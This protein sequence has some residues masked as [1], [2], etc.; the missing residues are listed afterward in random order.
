[1]KLQN[2]HSI[3]NKIY[4]FNRIN[5]EEMIVTE[6][7][8]FYPYFYEPD[9]KGTIPTYDGKLA[10]KVVLN[11]PKDVAKNRSSISYESDIL[12][13]KRYL[14]DRVPVIDFSPTKY[15]L[16]DIEILTEE[17]PDVDKA[18]QPISCITIYISTTKEYYTWYLG[19]WGGIMGEAIML[20]D[21]VQS[22]RNEQPDILCAWN[23]QFDYTYLFNRLAKNTPSTEGIVFSDAI[24]PI[25]CS[26]SGRD[27]IFFPAGISIVDYMGLY[28]KLTL[29]KKRSY[30]LDYIS[31]ED[32]GEV[33]WKETKFNVLDETVKAKNH[34]DVR[35]LVSL[36]D[37]YK[38]LVHFDGIRRFTKCLWEDL[39]TER[40]EIEGKLQ[41]IS[42]NSKPLDMVFLQ[43]AHD[44]G[45]VLPRKQQDNADEE[46]IE[47]A[48]R[49]SYAQGVFYDVSEYDLSG[50]YLY[51]AIDMCL[52]SS[53]IIDTSKLFV[54]DGKPWW[55]N[56]VLPINVTDRKTQDVKETYYV[57]QNPNALIP[58]VLSKLVNDKN[59]L[60]D[61]TLKN[62]NDENLE[63]EYKSKKGL[64]LSAWGVLVNKYFRLYDVRVGSM[65]T[66]IVRD[67]MHYVREKIEFKGYTVVKLDT[68]S[69]FV[70]DGGKDISELLNGIIKEWSQLR[71]GKASQITFELKGHF[72]KLLL[73]TNCRH[74]GY[75][76]G[77]TKPEIKGVEIKRSGSSK[78][79]AKFQQEL[80]ER[81]LEGDSKEGIVE[82][83]RGEMER[84]KTLPIQEIA[85][86]AKI[87]SDYEKSNPIHNRAAD[88]SKEMFKDFKLAKGDLFYY[89][90][91]E[92]IGN[93]SVGKPRD[94]L[95]FTTAY[96]T[97][98]SKKYQV[99]VDWDRVIDRNI[100]NKVETVFE[101]M[102]WGDSKAVL[103]GQLSLW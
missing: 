1:M 32:L 15:I 103:Q 23:I 93:D 30:A 100:L 34:N 3:G 54:K 18:E 49:D 38:V 75:L 102:N 46:G 84:I 35:R 56:D 85:F 45:I 66:S 47:G 21:F 81:I 26:R 11:N 89:T 101:I 50:A 77:R 59:K 16:F 94:V 68:D 91:I 86:P 78:Y 72:S 55:G 33:A 95:G 27:N 76:Q 67:L 70:R 43:E 7:H 25:G 57:R 48:F 28:Q 52:D 20:E 42:N 8:D 62:K 12:Y 79:E 51:A 64:V 65:I 31:Q 40:R 98:S 19:E 90:F 61:L 82:F 74:Y 92:P 22:I 63:Q 13:T 14:I 87:Q 6:V 60:R 4:L 97:F 41:T 36:E 73:L 99:K 44:S 83:V 24:S 2:I 39:A 37:K 71:F 88:N 53:N 80:F 58:K 69:F 96:D 5:P 17:F 10:R 29:G 9:P